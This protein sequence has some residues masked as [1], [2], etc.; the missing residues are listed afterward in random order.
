MGSVEFDNALRWVDRLVTNDGPT[1]GTVPSY[2]SLDSR[3]AWH[4]AKNVELSVVGQNLLQ[5]RHVEYGF[6]S[7]LREQIDRSVYAKIA[8]QF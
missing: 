2:F 4:C 6:P 7:P 8:W 3:L 5:P 1:P